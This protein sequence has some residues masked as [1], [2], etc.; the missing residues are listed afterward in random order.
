MN[1]YNKNILLVIHQGVLGGA[2]RQ[3][4]GISKYLTEECNC[5][6]DL[7]LTFSGEMNDEFKS[8]AKACGIREIKHFGHPY[9]LLERKFSYKN[10]NNLVRACRY[11]L[12]LRKGI[13][14]LKPDVII[15][16]MNFPSKVAF[17]LYKLLPSVKVTF[18]HQLGLDS[19]S[20]DI[21]EKVA[22]NNIPFVIGNASNCLDML[23]TPY[24]I[25]SSKL[26]VLPQYIAM[27]YQPN[28]KEQ[29][30]LQYNIPAN[31]VVIGM[32]A[33]YRPDKKQEL[34]LDTFKKL[35]MLYPQ[36]HLVFLGHKDSN[37]TT[38][39]KY[40]YLLQKIND[41]D[42]S[43]K[44]SLLSGVNVEDI[45]N[46]LD[47]GVLMSEVEGMPNV[48]MEYM[49]YKLPVIATNHPGCVQLLND[50]S[51]LIENDEL[52]LME[53]LKTLILSKEKRQVEAEIN[54]EKI[55]A[56]TLEDYVKKLEFIMNRYI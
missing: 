7:L 53:A 13:K 14:P 29:F 51:Y 41:Y 47:I 3:G 8:F 55:K 5:K 10:F 27:E 43:S 36:L 49:L 33:H 2:E 6:V 45:L 19:L 30:R 15:P 11:L 23:K 16:F 54:A 40:E 39:K 44:V 18:W 17:Y 4:L 28:D 38:I 1:L 50:S 25:E 32:I 22:I 26:N 24:V 56:F 12:K 48:V 35:N 46:M 34:L 9:L 42:L 37:K 20:M 31:A 52:Q 21:F